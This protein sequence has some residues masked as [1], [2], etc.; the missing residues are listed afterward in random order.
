MYITKDIK[1][2]IQFV[3]AHFGVDKNEQVDREADKAAKE[4]DQ[5]EHKVEFK[6]IKAAIKKATNNRWMMRTNKDT[7]RKK[8][9]EKR[10]NLKER[11]KMSRETHTMLLQLRCGEN[12]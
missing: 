10:T 8:V 5:K 12:K 9:T 1:I 4:S 3:A 6:A 7:E 2:T 11:D